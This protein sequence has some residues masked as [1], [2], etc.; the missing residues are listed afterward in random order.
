M[1]G[2]LHVVDRIP[3]REGGMC[4]AQTMG[5]SDRHEHRDTL[6]PK[7]TDMTRDRLAHARRKTPKLK[8]RT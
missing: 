5:P 4:V 6:T 3:R 8:K 2:A 7:E 1:R